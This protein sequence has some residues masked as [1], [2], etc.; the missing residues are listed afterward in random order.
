MADVETAAAPAPPV[1]WHLAFQAVTQ[2]YDECAH[3]LLLAQVDHALLA[4]RNR[5]LEAELAEAR[6]AG[7]PEIIEPGEPQ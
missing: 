2:L 3:K 1:N 5:Q 7:E 6:K 4:E